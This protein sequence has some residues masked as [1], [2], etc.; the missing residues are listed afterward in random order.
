MDKAAAVELRG[1]AGPVAPLQRL[2]LWLASLRGWRRHLAAFLLGAIAVLSLPPFNM[3]PVNFTPVLLISFPGLVW[4]TDGNTGYRSAL[5]LGWSFGFGF[6]L[7]GLYWIA[8]ALFVD[9]AQFWWLVPFAIAGV[10]AGLAIFTAAALLVSH[11]L[12]RL[13]RLGGTGRVFALVFCW[14]GAEWLRGHILSGFPWNLM[15]YTWSGAFPGALEMLQLAAIVGIYGLSLLTV[16]AASLPAR[17]GDFSGRRW[18]AL[19]AAV[20][21]IA[22]PAGWGAYRLA[23]GPTEDVPGIALRLVQPSI[24]QT[25]KQDPAALLG[26]FRRLFALSTSPASTPPTAIIWPEDAAPPFLE[27]DGGARQALAQAAPQNG[28]I[29]TGTTRTDAAPEAPTHV[30]NS[31][32]AVDH[33]GNIRASYDKFHLVP[34]G[35]YVPLRSVLPMQKITPGAI[36]F[37]AGPGPRT[38]TLPGLPPFSPLICYEAIFPHAVVDPAHR[39]DWLL[40]IT[41]DAWYGFTS[42]PFQH[43]A[44]ARLRAIEEGLPL[45]RAGD[46]GISA[47]F[48]PYG[49]FTARLALDD[50]GVL[51]VKL[52]RPLPPTLYSRIG[53]LPFFG[54]L[55]L[56]AATLLWP[57]LSTL[58]LARKA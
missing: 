47:M 45:A 36:D 41:D 33:E 14:C 1:K 13:L 53:D 16:L 7:A 9:I 30:W 21:L 28:Y 11:A 56:I 51:D 24:P 46:N 32:V 31:L 15:G 44:I 22:L 54:A 50:V 25:M 27:R 3:L 48:D 18:L 34:F 5:A 52:P 19:V 58:A 12:C 26:N 40:N 17:L 23:N 37:S 29:I 49:R 39:P 55:L 35:E 2:A 20:L 8:A 4:L 57:R 10:P 6:F 43:L 38:I 42:G